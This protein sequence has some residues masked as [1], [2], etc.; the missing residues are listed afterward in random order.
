MHNRSRKGRGVKYK[1]DIKNYLQFKTN[2]NNTN[3]YPNSNNNCNNHNYNINISTEVNNTDYS[4]SYDPSS[5]ENNANKVIKEEKEKYDLITTERNKNINSK[6]GCISETKYLG[7]DGSRR[8]KASISKNLDNIQNDNLN[9]SLNEENSNNYNNNSDYYK[10]KINNSISI[11]SNIII[12]NPRGRRKLI[13]IEDS[14]NHQKF[15][16]EIPQNLSQSKITQQTN[17]NIVFHEYNSI[18]ILKKHI[19]NSN[20]DDIY[21]RFIV[22]KN[23][24]EQDVL[25][26]FS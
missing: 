5:L 16:F 3:N 23:K 14:N 21:N 10:P 13:K 9:I 20:A 1:S 17:K 8:R 11:S 22:E 24:L 25:E 4:D 6:N 15:T 2:T 19:L 26:Y 18:I 12:K 7:G